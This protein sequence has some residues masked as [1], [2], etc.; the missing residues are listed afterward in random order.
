MAKIKFTEKLKA[1]TAGFRTVWEAASGGK[2]VCIVEAQSMK[3]LFEEEEQFRRIGGGALPNTAVKP[4]THDKA[5]DV[6]LKLY[7]QDHMGR[8]LLGLIADFIVGDG[9][10][11]AAKHQ[12]ENLQE[13]IQQEINIFWDDPV[14]AMDRMTPQRIE[15]WHLW[16]EICMPVQRNEANGRIR[17]G[18]ITP[19]SI[20]DVVPD[21]MTG[22]PGR[23][24]LTDQAARAV[25]QKELQVVSFTDGVF[26]GDAFYYGM[27]TVRGGGR[28]LPELFTAADL[29]SIYNN[30][31]RAQADRAKMDSMFLWDI[32][33]EG[34]SETEC[35]A[36]EKKLNKN[37]IRPNT[38]R[39]HNGKVK[40]QCV[41]PNLGSF[42]FDQHL[43]TLKGFIMG[44]FGIPNHWF[45]SGDDA[46]LA[47][48]SVMSEPTRKSLKRKQ[49][50]VG[51]MIGDIIRYMLASVQAAG[52][53]QGLNLDDGDPFEVNIP[54]ISGPDIAKVGSAVV[55]VVNAVT[56]AIDS[57]LVSKDTGMDLF[58]AVAGELGIEIDPSTEREKIEADEQKHAD[59]EEKRME[60]VQKE[61]D[62]RMAAA[63]NDQPAPGQPQP[64]EPTAVPGQE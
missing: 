56:T 1:S 16:G 10:T 6:S 24:V 40:W 49:K 38:N 27:N 35:E 58:A 48:A 55:Q 60:D 57:G 39:V 51:Y 34:A 26:S 43:K 9:I 44:G 63:G 5:Q 14:N 42:E 22:H 4:F 12:D 36:L 31:L 25:G 3:Q 18:W 61:L 2:A 64:P 29:I 59:D 7:Q 46:N 54:D 32:T 21:P 47:T 17:I 28:G 50:M 30:T 52:G 20:T 45:G 23:L 53:L 37:P 19:R 11:V 33:V 15:E 8:R 41:T 62:R 13:Q